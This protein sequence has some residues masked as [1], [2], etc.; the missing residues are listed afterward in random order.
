MSEE[1][2]DATNKIRHR[3]INMMDLIYSRASEVLV[4][5]HE[6][7]KTEG[8]AQLTPAI[9]EGILHPCLRSI[10]GPSDNRLTQ[11]C[12]LMFASTW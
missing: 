12:A 1:T 2:R 8:G 3:A 11:T 7:Q 5:D 9:G 10:L 4:L 6:L